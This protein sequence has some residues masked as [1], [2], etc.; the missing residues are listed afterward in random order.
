M[1]FACVAL[2]DVFERVK[3]ELQTMDRVI[4]H[5]LGFPREPDF[6]KAKHGDR[7][8]DAHRI[9]RASQALRLAILETWVA[10]EKEE[11]AVPVDPNRDLLDALDQMLRSFR[12]QAKAE[13]RDEREKVSA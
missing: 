11:A 13:L 12:R 3:R 2:A 5:E 9:V 6:S 10:M 4:G 8:F 1:F 7:V